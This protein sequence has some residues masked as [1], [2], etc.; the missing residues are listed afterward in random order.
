MPDFLHRTTKQRYHSFPFADLPEP[1]ANYIVDPELSA[2]LG[3]PVKY[4]VITGDVVTLAD[5]SARA[6]IDAAL[7][8]LVRDET[9]D[10]LTE[11]ESILRG[12]SLAIL[13]EFNQRN[14]KIV[15]ILDAIDAASNF[16]QV[17]ANIAAITD[18][19]QRTIAQ[20]KTAVRAKAG[21]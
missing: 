18:P 5:A 3:Q 21:L 1:V 17:K 12:L 8:V 13:D 6:A 16:S 9:A 15:E 10:F 14:D 7:L 4:W 11:P 19:P 20:L 2:V